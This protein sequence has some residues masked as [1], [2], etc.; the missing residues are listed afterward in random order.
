VA[1]PGG[2]LPGIHMNLKRIEELLTRLKF[3]SKFKSTKD[4]DEIQISC[5]THQNR[6]TRGWLSKVYIHTTKITLKSCGTL[7]LFVEI[8]DF[9]S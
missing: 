5:N 1:D 4:Y 8:L 3:R 6:F 9:L 2:V 7:N